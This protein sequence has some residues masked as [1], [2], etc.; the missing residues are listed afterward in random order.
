VQTPNGVRAIEQRLDAVTGVHVRRFYYSDALIND[1]ASVRPI[2]SNGLPLWQR[3]AVTLAWPRIVP[4]MIK[5]M[6]L[7]LQQGLQSRAILE[8]ELHWLEGML[9]DGR[10]YLT[11]NHWTR[12]D[13]TAAALLAPLAEPKEH[14]MVQAVVFPQ[15]V[16]ETM[17]TWAQR[18]A[19]QFVRRMYASHRYSVQGSI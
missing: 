19:V 10:P 9:A 13:L 2:F 15:T 1:P 14:P 5:G 18:P 16:L 3:A 17:Q 4:L 8:G 6:D 11:G 7:G 12:A